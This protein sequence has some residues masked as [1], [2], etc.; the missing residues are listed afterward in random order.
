MKI[1]FF[2]DGLPF[3]GDS[4]EKAPLG[5][6][7]SAFI[8]LTRA[9][10]ARG[11]EVV[12]YNNCSKAAMH[13]GV[14]YHPFRSDLARLAWENFDAFV[15]SRF[16][17]AFNLPI[18]AKLKVLWNHDTL[19]NAQVLKSVHDEID[20]FFVLSAFHRDNFLTR[21]PQLA[22]RMV[23]TR[24][25]L[26]FKLLDKASRGV[27][28]DPNKL[29]YASRPER[30]LKILLESIWPR[31]KKARPGLKLRLCGYHVDPVLLS[32]EL[33]ELYG[34]LDLLAESDP[35]IENLGP[36]SKKDYYRSLAESALV[37]YTCSFPE[38]SC[39][40]A[41]EA[42]ALGTPIL[43]TNDYALTESVTVDY[44]KVS[45]RPRSE[46]YVQNYVERALDLL[47]DPK[48]TKS[49]AQKAKASVRASHSWELIAGEWERVF[50]LG[51]RAKASAFNNVE[52]RKL[53]DHLL[54]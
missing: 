7:E 24:N 8:G 50:R 38:I 18:K 23:A 10:A 31:L 6:S 12:A 53:S 39:I 40:V 52:A 28:R 26:D 46:A 44:F 22:D 20:V 36:L 17:G 5:G 49:L 16:F 25:G 3:D 45:G 4:L 29:L 2:T 15:V 47:G 21:L 43:T 33:K 19:D 37:T 54:V 41:L 27:R 32:P 14:Q 42:Q 1:G 13:H 11:H 9:L 30:G 34:Y 35:D 48:K 51:L